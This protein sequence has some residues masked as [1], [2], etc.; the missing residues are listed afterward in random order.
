MY[1]FFFLGGIV[2]MADWMVA[3][4]TL[5]MVLGFICV[6][7]LYMAFLIIMSGARLFINCVIYSLI[8]RVVFIV[9]F[10]VSIAISQNWAVEEQ[11]LKHKIFKLFVK[12]AHFRCGSIS[13]IWEGVVIICYSI[14]VV[15]MYH[16]TKVT[17]SNLKY[18]KFVETKSRESFCWMKHFLTLKNL[19]LTSSCLVNL[20]L[21]SHKIVVYDCWK[22]YQPKSHYIVSSTI[23]FS[24]AL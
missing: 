1:N 9:A 2:C 8:N 5:W 20:L 18:H 21:T 10:F 7:I 19:C 4:V 6:I 13:R 24:I 16:D 15:L 11:E 14:N 22:Y 12:N 3:C 17:K 23:K